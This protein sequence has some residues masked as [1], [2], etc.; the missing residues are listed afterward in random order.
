L[1]SNA[2]KF[3]PRNGRVQVS[4]ERVNSQV[5]ITVSDSGQ[6]INPE[7]LPFVFDR[8]RQQDS[9]ITR[10]HSGLGLGLAIVRHLVEMHGGAVSAYSEGE[11]KGATFKVKLPILIAQEPGRFRTHSGK[12]EM[13]P[14]E[15]EMVFEP[16]S[17]LSGIR[18]LVVDD[19]PDARELLA[20]ILKQSGAELVT[21]DSTTQAIDCYN[22]EKPDLL[23]SDIEMPGEDGYS[24]IRKI[25]KIESEQGGWMPAIALTAHARAEDRVRAL[26]AGFQSHVAKPVEPAELVATISSLTRR[27]FADEAKE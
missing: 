13:P 14:I 23:I 9:T 24:L 11:G 15:S 5:E 22:T 7:F 12:L 16:S 8:F 18:L 26:A 6:G 25:R 2:A 20:S 17:A 1:L 10:E 4:L 19:D 27:P 21:A 3:T